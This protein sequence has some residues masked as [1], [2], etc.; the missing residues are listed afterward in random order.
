MPSPLLIALA[1]ALLFFSRTCAETET[2]TYDGSLACGGACPAALPHCHDA[3]AVCVECLDDPH[4]PSS[5][6]ECNPVSHVCERCGSD[7]DCGGALPICDAETGACRGCRADAECSARVGTPVCDESAG[8]CVACTPDSEATAC[9][10]YSCHRQTRTCTSTVRGSVGLCHECQADSECGS[11]DLCVTRTFGTTP[12]GSYCL[13]VRTAAG[14]GATDTNPGLLPHAFSENVTSV[15]GVAA[16]VCRPRDTIS[17]LAL[18]RFGQ[19]C[20]AQGSGPTDACGDSRVGDGQCAYFV[21]SSKY[22][23][24]YACVG[25][26]DCSAG[27]AC[28]QA[29]GDVTKVC[30]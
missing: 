15:E 5:K 16:T 13:R 19:G 10:I 6:P 29:G 17:C 12:L 26:D 30:R 18:Q 14:C 24:S 21:G 8:T 2:R 1:A 4:C 3:E 9:G 28:V 22:T 20:S 11:G 27:T 7:A 25:A 23:C